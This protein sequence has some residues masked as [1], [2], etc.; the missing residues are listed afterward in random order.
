M[1]PPH[2]TR[3]SAQDYS[4]LVFE[5]PTVH[6]H[7][8][9]T[10]IFASGPLK[11]ADGGI[12]IAA[13]KRAIGAVLHQIPRY[14][15]RLAWTPIEGHPVWVDD[16]Q[17][18]LDYH[19]R[20]TALPRPGGEEELKRL[21]ARVMAQQL[22]RARPLWETWVVE[23]LQGDRFAVIN[24]IHHCMLDGQA[25]VDL[26]QILLSPFAEYEPKEAP[27]YLPRTRP[28]GW[29]LFRDAALRR[30]TLPLQAIRGLGELQ[31]ET[32]SMGS[33]LLVR[34]RAVAN[35]LGWAVRPASETP[36]NGR[37]GPHRRFDWL[38][39]PFADFKATA[40]ALGCTI[41]DLVLATV[42]GAVREFLMAHHV[43]PDEIDFCVSAPV[44]VRREAERGRLGNRVSSWILQLPIGEPDPGRRLAAIQRV[45]QDLKASNQALGVETMMAIAEWT[46][47]V[48]LSLGA[49]AASGPINMIVTNV[50]GPQIPLYMLG[51]RLLEL[52]PQVPLLENTGLGIAIFS[53]DGKLFWGFNADYELVPD[54]RSFVKAIDRSFRDL[55]ALASAARTQPDAARGADSA[56]RGADQPTERDGMPRK[57]AVSP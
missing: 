41:N 54:L 3:L 7:V 16:R 26:A 2:Y 11:T 8:A 38:G 4:F 15:Q 31:S 53:Y 33:E 17:F 22:D 1:S 32:A 9:A 10:Q 18:N 35:L 44:S 24:K 52:Y 47:T 14:R 51:A 43:R 19:I 20:H 55:A 45:T 12:D 50:P 40:K 48:L 46:P 23:G 25:G 39:M 34:L 57:R 29:Q 6:M 49:R 27:Q 36:F 37:L 56:A 13:F 5:T 21:S 28:S 30:L 42:T